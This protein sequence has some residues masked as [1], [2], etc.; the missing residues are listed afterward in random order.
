MG[1]WVDELTILDCEERVGLFAEVSARVALR[2]L[3]PRELEVSY[4]AVAEQLTGAQIAE[5]LT[6]SRK[7]VELHLDRLRN[8]LDEGYA[9]GELNGGYRALLLRR[10]AARFWMRVGAR[11]RELALLRGAVEVAYVPGIP[12]FPLGSS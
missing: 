3:T 11:E 4:L 8:K 12:R 2:A 5:R 6:I 1:N 7:T 9:V 10:L